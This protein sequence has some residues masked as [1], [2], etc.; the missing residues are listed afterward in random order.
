[1]GLKTNSSSVFF[2]VVE[3]KI[4]KLFLELIRMKQMLLGLCFVFV[5]YVLFLLSVL[6]FIPLLLAVPL[7]F[8]SIL[9]T[10][11]LF[12]ERRRFKGFS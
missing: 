6:R 8:V 4:D 11:H 9:F 12:N 2:C 3:H 5:C 1:M 10:V 7:L